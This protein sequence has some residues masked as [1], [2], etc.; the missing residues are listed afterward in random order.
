MGAKHA[1]A[2]QVEEVLTVKHWKYR[3]KFCRTLTVD[4]KSLRFEIDSG[5]AV[6]NVSTSTVQSF[7]P[8][9]RL[10]STT[11]QLVTFCKTSIQIVGILPVSIVWRD[12]MH[13]LN[14]YVSKIEREPLLGREWIRQ[15]QLFQLV[16]SVNSTQ[17]IQESIQARIEKLLRHYREKLD[18]DSTKIHGLQ[19]S[20]IMKENAKPVFLKAYTVSFKLLPLVKQE[21]STL[22]KNEILEKL[23][24]HTGLLPSC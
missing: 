6:F 18:P 20:L 11:M 13:K 22:V 24:H 16:D 8:L 19:A 5:A 15:L 2:N 7:F 4:E 3:D 21:L 9:R 17:I 12:K 1:S 23:T 14:L 10:Q